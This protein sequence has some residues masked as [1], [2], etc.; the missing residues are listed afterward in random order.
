MLDRGGRRHADRRLGGGAGPASTRSRCSPASASAS[1][2]SVIPY[3]TDQLALARMRRSTYALLVALLPATATVIGV[4][5]LAQIPTPAGDHRR[6]ARDRRR[7]AVRPGARM[8]ARRCRRRRRGARRSAAA[9]DVL[10]L[11]NDAQRAIADAPGRE[12]A[13]GPAPGRVTVMPFPSAATRARRGAA[14]GRRRRDGGRDAWCSLRRPSP[15]ATP[16]PGPRRPSAA[17]GSRRCPGITEE[18]FARALAVDYAELKRAGEEIAARL[19]AA[20]TVRITSPAGTDVVLTLEGRTGDQ[21]R[22]RSQARRARSAT[23][24]PARASSPRSRPP[25][26]A[27]SCSTARSAATACSR[28]RCG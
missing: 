27:R 26:T 14:A 8:T 19:T 1:S 13:T 12:A 20:A 22:R 25:A 3:V 5:V 18:I 9:D 10:V 21:R 4:I 23:C 24:P 16:R 15:S 2:S 6:R 7:R 11:C 28:S 17:S